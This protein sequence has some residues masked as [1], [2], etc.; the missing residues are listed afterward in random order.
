MPCLVNL[1]TKYAT[2]LT[3]ENFSPGT[4]RRL[5]EGVEGRRGKKKRALYSDFM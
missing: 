1:Y 4:G 2:A 5:D 3:F